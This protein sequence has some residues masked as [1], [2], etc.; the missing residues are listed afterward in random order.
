METKYKRM[1]LELARFVSLNA[2]FALIICFL[3]M[4]V[5]LIVRAISEGLYNFIMSLIYELNGL[6]PKVFSIMFLVFF[7]TFIF[8]LFIVS[9]RSF[10]YYAELSQ[11]LQSMVEGNRN[12]K[13]PVSEQDS[14]FG[15]LAQNIN[16]LV[17]QL[18]LSL[19][20]ERAAEE[21]KNELITSVSHDLRTPLTSILGYLYIIEQD[22]YQDE[23]EMRYYTSIIYEKSKNLDRLVNELFEYVRTKS[24]KLSLHKEQVNLTRMLQQLAAQFIPEFKARHMEYRLF[25]PDSE[26]WLHADAEKLVRVYENLINNALQYGADGKWIDIQ[27]Q[28]DTSGIRIEVRNYG[29]PIPPYAIPYVFERFYRA[30][31]ARTEAGSGLGLAIA[32]N[33]VELHQGEIWVESDVSGTAFFTLFLIKENKDEC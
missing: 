28:E 24:P 31:Q 18:E 23:V 12:L 26:V 14:V 15:G 7:F 1:R 4:A 11:T 21:S 32:K 13:L 29:K 19:Q 33:I 27:L 25:L 30:D 20:Q 2:V 22:R 10:R 6:L 9:R 3:L 5:I 8:N 17:E 16:K